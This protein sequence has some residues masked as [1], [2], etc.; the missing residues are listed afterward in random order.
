MSANLA[1][2]VCRD[3]LFAALA[4]SAVLSYEVSVAVPVAAP[5]TV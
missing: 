3:R 1:P 2:V 5:N 4:S